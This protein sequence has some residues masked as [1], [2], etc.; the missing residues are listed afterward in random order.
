[1]TLEELSNKELVEEFKRVAMNLAGGGAWGR[2]L[3][4]EVEE[5]LLS[6]LGEEVE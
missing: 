4:Y 5:E 3:Y 6:R 2:T 1:M